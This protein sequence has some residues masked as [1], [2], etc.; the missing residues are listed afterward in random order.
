MGFFFL[1]VDDVDY[2]VCDED[3]G[4]DDAGLVDEDG[5]VGNG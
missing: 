1:P 2:A 5:A 4:G 3:V